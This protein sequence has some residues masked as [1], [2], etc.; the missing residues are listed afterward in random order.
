VEAGRYFIHAGQVHYMPV[1]TRGYSTSPSN[2]DAPLSPIVLQIL[3]LI[4]GTLG[5]ASPQTCKLE[6]SV[7]GVR[8]KKILGGASVFGRSPLLLI[9]HGE[10][11]FGTAN[12]GSHGCSFWYNSK[13]S[14]DEEG[15]ECRKACFI[16]SRQSPTSAPYVI[17][18]NVRADR[19]PLD[20]PFSFSNNFPV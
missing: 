12:H 10:D 8:A 15:A 5:E 7:L 3:L 14:G 19:E 1:Y 18:F 4:T 20:W 17:S 13:C 11:R 9:E 16:S 6:T 2:E